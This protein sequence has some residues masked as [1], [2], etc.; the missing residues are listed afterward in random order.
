MSLN[1][2]PPLLAVA[3]LAFVAAPA[4]A[5]VKVYAEPG[6]TTAP[7]CVTTEFLVFVPNE[8]PDPTVRV[9]LVIPPAVRIIDALPVPGWAVTLTRDKGRVARVTWSGGHLRPGEYQRFSL[10]GTPR[11]AGTVSWD[12]IQTYQGGTVVA[13]TGAPGSDTPHS[14]IAVTPPLKAADCNPGRRP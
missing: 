3:A 9:D 7:A 5:H 4:A 10:Y 6:W 13:W 1:R 2:L 8:R 14:Q 11:I 12:A